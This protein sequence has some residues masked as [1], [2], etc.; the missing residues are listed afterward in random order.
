MCSE[1]TLL[2]FFE[3]SLADDSFLDVSFLDDS[4]VETSFSSVFDVVILLEEEL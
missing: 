4:A 3:L 2:S 1:E